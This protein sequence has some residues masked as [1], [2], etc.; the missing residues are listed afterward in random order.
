M[1]ASLNLLLL[2]LWKALLA[3]PSH[4]PP[5]P[6]LTRLPLSPLPVTQRF[7]VC[8][9]IVECVRCRSR[10]FPTDLFNLLP[11][12]CRTSSPSTIDFP[13][14]S[15]QRAIPPLHPPPSTLPVSTSFTIH[16]DLTVYSIDWFISPHCSAL[17][18]RSRL[19]AL[20]IHFMYIGP[21][22]H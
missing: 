1:P 9:G 3:S 19:D 15:R 7:R 12:R 18:E 10:H 11:C 17:L 22:G 13:P 8:S 4:Y 14:D 21:M 16:G 6:P 5:P 2:K 20:D